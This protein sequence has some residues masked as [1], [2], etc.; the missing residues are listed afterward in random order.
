MSRIGD[1]SYSFL[2]SDRIWPPGFGADLGHPYIKAL[3]EV[4]ERLSDDI[5]D[6]VDLRLLFVFELPPIVAIN[7]PFARPY[8]PMKNCF[9]VRLDTVIIFHSAINLSNKALIGLFA[10]EIAHTFVE[11]REHYQNEEAT[12]KLAYS[13]GFQE[14]L[15]LLEKELSQL[16][17]NDS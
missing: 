8:P 17:L 14:E 13:W 6:E 10:H 15:D 1:I 4:L 2:K 11:E 9:T 16:Q 3:V 5:Y 7:C 12:N